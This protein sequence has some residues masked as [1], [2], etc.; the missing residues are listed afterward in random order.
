MDVRSLSP[1]VNVNVDIR[2]KT[3]HSGALDFKPRAPGGNTG[4]GSRSPGAGRYPIW[5]TA[6]A[7][8]SSILPP[9]GPREPTPRSVALHEAA[10]HRI[11]LCGVSLPSVRAF[12][13]RR[14]GLI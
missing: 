5:P 3:E 14:G 7:A 9:T 4:G 8:P 2:A 12:G 10:R 13:S 6:T 11:T 1:G